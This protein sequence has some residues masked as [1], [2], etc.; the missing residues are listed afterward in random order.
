[1]KNSILLIRHAQ[2]AN[3]A[4]PE[5]Q[6]VPDPGLTDLGHRQA[7]RL[8]E[9]IKQFPVSQLYCSPFRRSL[10]TTRPCS[11]A[12]KLTPTVDSDIYEQGGCYSGHIPGQLRGAPGMNRAELQRDYPEWQIC[13][14]IGEQGW[15]HGREYETEHQAIQRAER[16]AHRLTT[17]WLAEFPGEVAALVIHADFKR[18]LLMA[19]LGTD[20]WDEH[21]QPIYN[22]AVTHLERDGNRWQLAQ[23]NSVTHLTPELISD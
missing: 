23:W 2:S 15:N 11:D 19:L 18:I 4:L 21:W 3:N 10:D 6:R 5:S 13:S 22:T 20:R 12:L 8:A 1:M 17:R 16:V 14:T 9:G 7:Q